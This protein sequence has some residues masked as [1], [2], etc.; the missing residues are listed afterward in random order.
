VEEEVKATLD[1]NCLIDLDEKRQGHENVKYLIEKCRREQID[2]AVLGISASEKRKDGSHPETFDAFKERL[3]ALSIGHLT[4]LKPIGFWDITYWDN[5]LCSNEEMAAVHEQI[6]DILFSGSPYREIRP[7][8]DDRHQAQHLNR[9]CDAQAI[10]AHIWNKRDV[11]VTSDGN[12]HKD[13]KKSKLI[14]M[15]AGKIVRPIDFSV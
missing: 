9:V 11:F 5:C 7:E 6:M 1:T 10:W 13:S 15:G 2:V 8:S 3:L 12:F 14:E 4:I